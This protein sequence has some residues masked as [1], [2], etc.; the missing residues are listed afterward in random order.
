MRPSRLVL[1]LPKAV[2]KGEEPLK[3]FYQRL[4]DEVT[5]RGGQVDLVP[6]DRTFLLAEV[7]EDDD[8]HIVDH[9]ALRHPRILNAGVAYL[10]PFWNLD[11]H[12]IR[13]LSSIGA[14]KFRRSDVDSSAANDFHR[15]MVRCWVRPRR[16][17]GAQPEARMQLPS[18][19]IAV[20]L[21]S[22]ADRAVEET[23][24]L[25]RVSMVKALL[26]RDD[27]RPLVIKP[28]PRDHT[29]KTRDW[30]ASLAARDNRII[31]TGGNI[32]DILPEADVTVTIN[33]AVGIESFLH[34]VPVVL[35]GRA[36]FHHIATTVEKPRELDTAITHAA[37]RRW[38]Y[39]R[40]LYWYFRMNCVDAGSPTLIDDVLTRIAATGYDTDR[41]G[42]SGIAQH[43]PAKCHD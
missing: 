8:F 17:R 10:F 18:G 3:R 22:E 26:R 42:L 30:L 37:G 36:D 33:S 31:V 20:F 40:F 5:A 24:H 39:A 23:C 4:R 9:G 38:P 32:H 41:F 15:E 28:H 43:A 16:S 1:H 11:P 29:E 12:G 35:C 34:K 6:H 13:A 25:D 19:C 2:L 7:M 27:P 14:A 21:Q